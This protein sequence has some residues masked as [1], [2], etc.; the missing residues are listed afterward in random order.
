MRERTTILVTHSPRL[1]RMADRVVR[2]ESAGADSIASSLRE[3]RGRR[4]LDP[5]LPQLERLL[6]ADTMAEVLYVPASEVAIGRVVYKPGELV[7][8][9]YRAGAGDAVATCIAGVDLAERARR[10]QYAERARR[11]SGRAP[12]YDDKL[13]T[14]V[15]WLPFDPRL[16]ALGEELS[17]RF[18]VDARPS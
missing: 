1:A 12:T 17:R 3:H 4:A 14:L 6:D 2:V 9:H 11:V 16:P 15:T 13:E 8:V 10:P 18:G 7:A 5:A